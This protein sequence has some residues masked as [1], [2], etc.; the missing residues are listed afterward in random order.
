MNEKTQVANVARLLSRHRTEAMGLACIS[1]MFMHGMKFFVHPSIPLLH[2]FERFWAQI[3]NAGVDIFLFSSGMGCLYSLC[4][5]EKQTFS[6]FFK[7]RLRRVLIPYLIIALPCWGIVHSGGL[8]SLFLHVSTLY[9]WFC[10][11]DGMWFVPFILFCYMA[12]YP[13]IKGFLRIKKKGFG[14]FL[15]LSVICTLSML[16]Q[17]L[18]PQVVRMYRVALFRLPSF[19]LGIYFGY[20]SYYGKGKISIVFPLLIALFVVAMRQ[21]L[22]FPNT[23]YYYYYPNICKSVIYLVVALAIIDIGKSKLNFKFPVFNLC[24]RLSLEIYLLHMFFLKMIYRFNLENCNYLHFVYYLGMIVAVVLA[25][26]VQRI[27]QRFTESF[28]Q[29]R[30]AKPNPEK[31]A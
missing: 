2:Y 20:L 5:H 29:N 6:S 23:G 15:L 25:C 8:A 12:G 16:V 10:G 11:N 9:F 22:K 26:G 24:G 18:A 30:F 31:G 4:K 19:V 3:G 17:S 27:A 28:M 14:I 21:L 7:N 1:I 13:L